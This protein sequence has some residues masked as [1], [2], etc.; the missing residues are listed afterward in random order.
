MLPSCFSAALS[1]ELVPGDAVVLRL[2]SPSR[3][4]RRLPSHQTRHLWFL[5]VL[6]EGRLRVQQPRHRLTP[7]PSAWAGVLLGWKF[8]QTKTKRNCSVPFPPGLGSQN[9]LKEG[10]TS[11]QFRLQPHVILREQHLK[12]AC[13]CSALCG[14]SI[15][16][17]QVGTSALC[18]KSFI[19]IIY[20][21]KNTISSSIKIRLCTIMCRV[22][23]IS[24]GRKDFIWLI[25]AINS[26]ISNIF[27][28]TIFITSLK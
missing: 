15:S 27:T 13:C 12:P 19:S 9:R 5:A 2:S 4:R 1:E 28:A 8:L 18:L 25:L 26:F 14:N 24:D 10:E 11:G 6:Q 16:N 23:Y 21:E 22:F 3:R 7:P 17:G 20:P